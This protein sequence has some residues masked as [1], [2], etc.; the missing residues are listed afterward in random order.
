MQ[1]PV[2][3]S[4][5]VLLLEFIS[6]CDPATYHKTRSLFLTTCSH[7]VTLQLT[8]VA[9]YIDGST[10]EPDIPLT[11][12]ILDQNDNPPYFELHTGNITEASK[13][14]AFIF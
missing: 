11:V 1:I 5:F 13:E 3:V 14:G 7:H 8:G 10:A 12:T 9:K 2:T 6:T 4:S